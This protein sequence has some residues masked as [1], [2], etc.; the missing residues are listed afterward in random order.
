MTCLNGGICSLNEF[1]TI[2]KIDILA[3][4]SIQTD[5]LEYETKT[6]PQQSMNFHIIISVLIVISIL[7]I[8]RF[9]KTRMFIMNLD[10]Y[11]Q[12]DDYEEN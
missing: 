10:M 3:Y 8:L 1:G 6:V 12:Q 9:L 4:S 5:L 7:H 11:L 2:D